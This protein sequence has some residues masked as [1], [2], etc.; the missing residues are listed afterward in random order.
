MFL[1]EECKYGNSAN[2]VK[3]MNERSYQPGA[4]QLMEMYNRVVTIVVSLDK[5]KQSFRFF[6]FI[7]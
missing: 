1:V 5:Y 3:Y 7:E 2:K 6:V 4:K